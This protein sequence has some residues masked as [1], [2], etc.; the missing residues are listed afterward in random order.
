MEYIEYGDL[1]GYMKTETGR[2]ASQEISRQIL[3]GL[4]MLHG[5]SICHRDLKP[6]VGSTLRYPIATLS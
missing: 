6:Q 2:A 1:S 5:E 4:K 3:E